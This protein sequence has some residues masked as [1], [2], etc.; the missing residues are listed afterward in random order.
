MN[1]NQCKPPELAGSSDEDPRCSY[2]SNN[3]K[4]QTGGSKSCLDKI[5][6][7]K[8]MDQTPNQHMTL[9]SCTIELEIR[10]DKQVK[11]EL[12]ERKK[13]RK[14]GNPKRV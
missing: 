5:K 13:R 14:K 2:F 9:Y 8:V 10:N 7:G 3:D 4:W 12:K 6:Q 11:G 1:K